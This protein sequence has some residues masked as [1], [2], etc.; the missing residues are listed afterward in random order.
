MALD[1]DI[2]RLAAIPLLAELDVEAL[3]LIAFAAETRVFRA[4]DVLFSKDDESNGGFVVLSGQIALD[5]S[6][7]GRSASQF[8]GP[9]A[10]IG[11]MALITETRRSVTAI[12]RQPS[13]ALWISRALF[14]RVLR[15]FPGS[16]ARLQ[17]V[18]EGR[19]SS[20][21]KSARTVTN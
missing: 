12:A 17:A 6:D 21:S 11:E 4:G 10:L 5:P 15:E 3:R 14:H 13:V 18:I 9:D 7:D 2:K 16:A 19:L 8:V 20:F 1:A